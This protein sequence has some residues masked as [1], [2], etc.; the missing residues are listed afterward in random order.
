MKLI[1]T[2]HAV[3]QGAFYTE[4]FYEGDKNVFNA[5]YD[6]GTSN[7]QNNLKK[8]IH[9][10]FAKGSTINYLF[11]SHF[12]YDHYSG[13]KYLT[14]HCNIEHFVVPVI[15]PQLLAESTLHNYIWVEETNNRIE[16][17]EDML[18][19]TREIMTA[20]NLIEIGENRNPQSIAVQ[21]SSS[22]V[23]YPYNPS[24]NPINDIIEEMGKNNSLTGLADAFIQKDFGRISELIRN[25]KL[26]EL[27]TVYKEAFG[28]H[29]CY[30][31][32]V[33]SGYENP[34]INNDERVCLFT[35]DYDG[36]DLTRINALTNPILDKW[37][38][39]GTFQVPHH[40]SKYSSCI[41]LY[42]NKDRKYVISS[43]DQS[44]NHHPHNETLGY[45]CSNSFVQLQL[46]KINNTLSYHYMI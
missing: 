9:A 24:Q 21:N 40:G 37:D 23:Y 16:R 18:E 45:I 43:C 20:E 26:S 28:N 17:F 33:Y 34:S 13:I 1:R 22:W 38:K 11:I 3:G 19:F 41:E 29:H 36:S 15:T 14:E 7:S 5:V 4:R 35:G 30:V 12:H 42:S 39:V 31:M 25:A 2:F 44:R 27:R 46:V 10:E 8:S 32:P 6:C